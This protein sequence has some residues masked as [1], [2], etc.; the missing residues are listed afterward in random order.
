LQQSRENTGKKENVT[1]KDENGGVSHGKSINKKP[2]KSRTKND[3]KPEGLTA[4][5]IEKDTPNEESK[6]EEGL[7][8]KIN[9]L[10]GETS[11]SKETCEIPGKRGIGVLESNQKK[12]TDGFGEAPNLDDKR[13]KEVRDASE[14]VGGNTDEITKKIN[15]L[16]RAHE[17]LL[18]DNIDK[19][20]PKTTKEIENGLVFLNDGGNNN[21]NTNPESVASVIKG[22]EKGAGNLSHQN[23][24]DHKPTVNK[25]SK[26]KRD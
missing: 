8:K 10:S 11:N 26:S 24:K 7:Q 1:K 15:M 21:N 19:I 18:P 9:P 12:G 16:S 22:D 20:K 3:S 5:V 2:V 25:K 4:S 23:S 17:G 13:T 6:S 14:P